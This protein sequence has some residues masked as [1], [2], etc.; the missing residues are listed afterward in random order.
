ME[1][2][3][4]EGDSPVSEKRM[5]SWAVHPSTTGHVEPCGNSGGPPSKAKYYPVTDSELVP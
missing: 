3:T 1:S 2:E 5:S 4:E